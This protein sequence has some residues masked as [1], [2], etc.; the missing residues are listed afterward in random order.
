MAEK[1]S[2]IN[3]RLALK[4]D[5]FIFLVLFFYDE[6]CYNTFNYMQF[7]LKVDAEFHCIGFSFYVRRN[8]CNYGRMEKQI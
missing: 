2:S 3:K 4:G 5:I 7:R 6:A 8:A 1:E